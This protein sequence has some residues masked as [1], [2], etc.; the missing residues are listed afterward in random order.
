MYR[1]DARD[2]M[3]SSGRWRDKNYN[4]HYHKPPASKII[5]IL[6]YVRMLSNQSRMQ[7]QVHFNWNQWIT[8]TQRN[9]KLQNQEAENSR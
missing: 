5:L 1:Q 7:A 6:K 4:A 8:V 3:Q 2:T 9:N